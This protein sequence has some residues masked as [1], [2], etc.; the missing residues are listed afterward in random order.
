VRMAEF[1][2]VLVLETAGK[3]GQVAL[4]SGDEVLAEDRLE[5]ARRRA[6]DLALVVDRLLRVRGWKARELTAV[7]VGLGPGSYTGL[8]VGLASAKALA[9]A[10]GCA[11]FG[12]ETFAAIAVRTP[13]ESRAV[14]VVADALQ[15]KLFRRDYR[16][17]TPGTW[18]P[19]TDLGVISTQEWTRS[20]A[21]E[22]WVSGPAAGLLEGKLAAGHRVV[23]PELRD[24]RPADIL[25]V[26]RLWPWAVTSDAWTAEPL[27]LR[28]SSAEEKAASVAT[29]PDRAR[30]G[31]P[32]DVGEAGQQTK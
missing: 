15:G 16:P 22:T 19:A 18:Q 32:G 31:H 7:V 23:P 14:S 11:F 13:V 6:S 3:V 21:V 25:A 17:T 4:A 24:P 30:A 29:G 1:D 2:R 12:V 10:A 9:Y 20:L 28:G 8:R 26:A 27:Y 5:G